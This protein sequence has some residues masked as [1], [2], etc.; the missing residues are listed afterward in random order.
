MKKLFSALQPSGELTLGNYLGSISRFPQLEKEYESII[1][2][3]DMHSI[4][5][6]QDPELLHKRNKVLIAYYM[7]SGMTKST[8]V[9]Q[10]EV[11]LHAEFAWVFEC[12][13]NMGELSR[14]TQFKAKTEGK[15]D[16]AIGCGLFTYP[17]LMAADIL[18]YDTDVVPVGQD[19][20]QHVELARNVAER[21]NSRFSNTFKIPEP[22]IPQVAAKVKDLQDPLKK[23]SKSAQNT[24]GVIFLSDDEKTIR[25]K[26]ASAVTDTDNYVDFDEEKKPGVS[27]LITI[28]S[29]I[30][31]IPL[32]DA[33]S[34]F[35]GLTK[36]GEL[37]GCVADSVVSKLIPLQKKCDDILKSG[38]VDK[39]LDKGRDICREKAWNKYKEV[40][41]KV[42]FGR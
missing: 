36:Y 4:T 40:C 22:I 42:G 32:K 5:V 30:N 18:I 39:L 14:M 20:K 37:K 16:Q 23:M 24:K 15:K 2:V 26:I 33:I 38:D 35:K 9:I 3:A 29:A 13:T 8:F 21:F 28:Y 17:L 31:S 34:K 1:A 27:N 41:Q 6:P 7:A 19:Q 10:S 25:K 12:I 11:G